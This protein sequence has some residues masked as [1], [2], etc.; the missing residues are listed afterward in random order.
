MGTKLVGVNELVVGLKKRTDLGAVKQV[1][2]QNGSELQHKEKRA[3]PVAPVNGGTLKR[4]IG[5]EI[6]DGGTAAIV[7]PTAHYGP[8]VEYGTR[9]MDA[10]PYAW[11]SFCKQKEQFKKDLEKLVK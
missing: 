11:P 4:S 1:V 6:A 2:K 8:Y 5:L 9:F 10:Q 7:E 3:V